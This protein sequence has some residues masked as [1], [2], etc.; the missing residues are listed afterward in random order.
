MPSRNDRSALIAESF[1]VAASECSPRH[2]RHATVRH[3][4]HRACLGCVLAGNTLPFG[5]AL[6]S[7]YSLWNGDFPP[8]RSAKN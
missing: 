5:L 4:L 6:G 8:E 1:E 7:S 3:R 2:M